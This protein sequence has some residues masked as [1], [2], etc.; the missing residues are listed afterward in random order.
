MLNKID[1]NSFHFNLPSNRHK[2]FTHFNMARKISLLPFGNGFHLALHAAATGLSPCRVSKVLR[3]AEAR[4]E[5]EATVITLQGCP[6]SYQC[7]AVRG[8][9]SCHRRHR[10]IALERSTE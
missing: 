2:I 5:V 7:A 8:R 10:I 6:D 9:T 4:A 3:M 1:F